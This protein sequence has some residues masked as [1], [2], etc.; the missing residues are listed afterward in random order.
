MDYLISQISGLPK[1]G[2]DP[3]QYFQG[4]DNKKNLTAKMRNK[5]G[6][7]KDKRV[8]II[9]TIN[10]QVVRVAAKLLTIKIV[11]K[12]RPNQCTAR[13]IASVE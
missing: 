9:D 4:K 6:I 10:D 7:I 1:V 12:N 11:R 13:V 3:L 8:Y 5:Y 2:V